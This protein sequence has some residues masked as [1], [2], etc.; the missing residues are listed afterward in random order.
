MAISSATELI[1]KRLD[2]H[3]KRV[4]YIAYRLA[5]QLEMAFDD[6]IDVII[7]GLIHDVG[8]IGI[9]MQLVSLNWIKKTFFMLKLGTGC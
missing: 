2:G 3:N 5:A 8:I 7:S 9:K 6:L 4:A 1:E